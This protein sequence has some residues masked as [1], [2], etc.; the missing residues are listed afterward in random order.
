MDLSTFPVSV[1]G[2]REGG[3]MSQ[4]SVSPH[5]FLVVTVKSF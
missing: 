5:S 4:K 3:R 2:G 1:S